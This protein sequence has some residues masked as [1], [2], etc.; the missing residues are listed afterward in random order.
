MNTMKP[1]MTNSGKFCVITSN[2]SNLI[3]VIDV[4]QQHFC[5][6]WAWSASLV[7]AIGEYLH[8]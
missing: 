7:S 2:P 8:V 5:Y 4:F 3:Q 6:L 1:I